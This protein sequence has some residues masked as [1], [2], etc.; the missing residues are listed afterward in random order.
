MAA[1]RHNLSR[2][3]V[4]GAV[5][6]ACASRRWAGVAAAASGR[7]APSPAPCRWTQALAGFR[8]AEARLAALPPG[9]SD[10]LFDDFECARLDALRSLLRAPAPDRPA[11]AVK[12]DF[13]IDDQAWELSGAEP[14]LAT[15]K[16]DAHRLLGGGPANSSA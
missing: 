2:R 1:G 6:G 8:R 14:C 16:E 9:N 12:I 7:A 11:L 10:D 4:L 15:L 13:F 3:A 5:A